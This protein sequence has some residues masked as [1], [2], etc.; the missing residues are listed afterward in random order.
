MCRGGPRSVMASTP[1][2]HAGGPGFKSRCRPT[3][4]RAVWSPKSIPIPR[5]K[6]KNGKGFPEE[7]E[8]GPEGLWFRRA[9][10]EAKKKQK[11]CVGTSQSTTTWA[12]GA[13]GRSLAAAAEASAAATAAAAA[14]AGRSASSPE[15]TPWVWSP[16]PWRA[17]TAQP[18]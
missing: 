4:F 12:G 7:G 2:S 3:N 6:S 5:L 11:L 15:T 14:A 8:V 18:R 16:R 10:R 9:P 1:D 17:P 13:A